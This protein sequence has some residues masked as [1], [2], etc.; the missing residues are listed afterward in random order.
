MDA[1]PTDASEPPWTYSDMGLR[2]EYSVTC[3]LLA[4]S[5]PT[6]AVS[7]A[8]LSQEYLGKGSSEWHLTFPQANGSRQSPINL[9]SRDAVYDSVLNLNPLTLNYA[10][11]RETDIYN[12]GHTIV[13]YPR[14]KPIDTG[15]RSDLQ[16]RSVMSGGPLPVGHEFELAEMRFHW[17]RED[18]RG[19]E[20]T[21]NFKAFPME[22]H[23]IHWNTNLYTSLEDALGKPQGV[24]IIALFIQIGREHAGLKLITECL[25][26]VQHKGRSR[27]ISTAFN[28]SYFLPDPLLRDYWTYPGSLTT[29]PCS[30]EV[31][32]LLFRYPLTV[33]HS[34]IEE[35][36][37]LRTHCKGDY[38]PS[39]DDG[40]MVDNFR[41]TQLLGD[42]VVRASFQ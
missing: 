1:V 37:R 27:T 8:D 9:N 38:P 29:P 5:N 4:C 12:V 32:W 39:G 18:T 11:S 2:N 33:S 7:A 26:D 6:L 19:S 34:Q 31:T 17:G 24:A 15:L 22:L 3:L 16:Q 41:A 20:H 30:E 21:V 23:M 13:V 40:T 35:F 28:P 14:Y 36:R 10:T 25:E 42:R